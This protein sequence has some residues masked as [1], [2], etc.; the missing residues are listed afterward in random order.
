MYD[1]RS[2]RVGP[3]LRNICPTKNSR[4]KLQ[5]ACYTWN[6]TN[7]SYSVLG[8]VRTAARSKARFD[9]VVRS[10]VRVLG[11]RILLSAVLLSG[12]C[13][14]QTTQGLIIGQVVAA[15]T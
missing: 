9:E 13:L 14:A 11:N 4:S 8:L 6:E 10:A 2:T 7:R 1:T 5:Q 12:I 15:T 3:S